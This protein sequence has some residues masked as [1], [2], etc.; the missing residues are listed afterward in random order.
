MIITAC[1]Y[2]KEQRK[3]EIPISNH[4]A[5]NDNLKSQVAGSACSDIKVILA[6]GTSTDTEGTSYQRCQ[7]CPE[8]HR[9]RAFSW[10]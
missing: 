7:A 10:R 1:M 9:I 2:K 5:C 8:T 4:A 6:I 3:A